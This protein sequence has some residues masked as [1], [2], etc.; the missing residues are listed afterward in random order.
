[1]EVIILKQCSIALVLRGIDGIIFD[2]RNQTDPGLMV[3]VHFVCT[4]FLYSVIA[5]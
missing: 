4:M 3:M 1:M 5:R 2:T